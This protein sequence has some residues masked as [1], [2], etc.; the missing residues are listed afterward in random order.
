MVVE[1]EELEGD[2]RRTPR[3]TVVPGDS[4]RLPTAPSS[5]NTR[6]NL[7][8]G[9]LIGL[10]LGIGYAVI[11]HVLDQRVRNPRDI[12]RETGV[13]VIGT[14]PESKDLSSARKVLT[15]YGPRG[16]VDA[17]RRGDARAAHQ[18]ALHRHRQPAARDRRHE[19]DPR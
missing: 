2:G 19:P 18:P 10:A 3:V 1:I 7:A 14:L 13:S 17:G 4:A 8:L 16:L 5:P 12:E 11:R 6:L 15:F 9:G